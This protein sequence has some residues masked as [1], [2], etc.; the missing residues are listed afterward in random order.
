MFW[1][2]KNKHSNKRADERWMRNKKKKRER[3]SES[4]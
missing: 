2:N 1:P 4:R 3:G